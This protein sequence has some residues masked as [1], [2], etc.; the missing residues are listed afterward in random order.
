MPVPD[1]AR[2]EHISLSDLKQTE[3][4]AVTHFVDT[5]FA[6]QF[7]D[8]T[9]TV[10]V[11]SGRVYSKTDVRTLSSAVPDSCCSCL[12]ALE[13][14]NACSIGCVC[15]DAPTPLPPSDQSYLQAL[16]GRST[17]YVKLAIGPSCGFT[18]FERWT[19][20]PVWNETLAIF[21]RKHDAAAPLPMRVE[22]WDRDLGRADDF[23]GALDVEVPDVGMHERELVLLAKGR[24]MCQ[25]TL[26]IDVAPMTEAGAL[27]HSSDA[28]SMV[29]R[30]Q[31]ASATCACR[32]PTGPP[33]ATGARP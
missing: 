15:E 30:G 19:L 28:L 11:K 12:C 7:L 24:E 8:K 22:M 13:S 4:R 27:H 17:P 23:I 16:T 3:L 25:V 26:T 31:Q 18:H 29:C 14:V 20:E 1:A 9:V 33:A 32:V 2:T 10:T 6:T 5:D 21:T